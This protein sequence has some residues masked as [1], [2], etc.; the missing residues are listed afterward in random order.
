MLYWGRKNFFAKHKN[1]E[2]NNPMEKYRAT[3]TRPILSFVIIVD[4]VCKVNYNL[5]RD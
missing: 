5:Y 4:N 2:I 3:C 1:K